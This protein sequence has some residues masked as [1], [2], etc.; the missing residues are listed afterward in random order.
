[1]FQ[2]VHY[3]PFSMVPPGAL[4]N[5]DTLQEFRVSQVYPTPKHFINYPAKG[6]ATPA[7]V[8]ATT[9]ELFLQDKWN[10]AIRPANNITVQF[11]PQPVDKG[12]WTSLANQQFARGTSNQQRQSITNTAV[13]G[14]APNK[15][16]Y[17]GFEDGY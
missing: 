12:T 7:A 4:P 14:S 5:A 2:D 16:I 8:Y 6:I 15:G 13:A 9:G 3:T 10:W 1:M 11:P 17:T